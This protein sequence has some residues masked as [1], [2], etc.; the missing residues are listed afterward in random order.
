MGFAVTVYVICMELYMCDLQF[1]TPLELFSLKSCL[2][3]LLYA[4]FMHKA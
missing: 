2:F 3:L 1:S 4:S